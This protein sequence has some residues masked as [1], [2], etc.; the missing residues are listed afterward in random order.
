M[1]CLGALKALFSEPA[2]WHF[3][4]C[5]KTKHQALVPPRSQQ[6]HRTEPQTIGKATHPCPHHP[7]DFCP[8]SCYFSLSV[9]GS[10]LGLYLWNTFLLSDTWVYT[11]VKCKNNVL[12]GKH[13]PQSNFSTFWIKNIWQF[14]IRRFISCFLLKIK[15]IWPFWFT[16]SNKKVNLRVLQSSGFSLFLCNLPTSITHPPFFCYVPELGRNWIRRHTTLFF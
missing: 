7:A 14:H 4:L 10:A 5:W 9:T 12:L 2:L 1:W 13:S 3:F 8:Y 15:V 11:Q 6:W 16:H